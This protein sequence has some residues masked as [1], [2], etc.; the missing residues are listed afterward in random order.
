MWSY[1]VR[2]VKDDNG[3]YL[4]TCRKFSEVTTYGASQR[5]ALDHARD[6]VEEAIAAR[7]ADR[8]PIPDPP[9]AS[10]SRHRVDLSAQTAVKILLY[11][12]MR[13]RQVSKKQLA[14]L[15]NCHRPQIDRLLNLRHASR[16]DAMEAAFGALGAQMK[17][18][19]ERHRA[20]Q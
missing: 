7:M 6:A 2:L 4:V 1:P 16:L 3:T 19:V 9:R 20:G 14:R 10:K 5:S 12:A 8:Q 17:I 11:R 18:G 15:L 13:D